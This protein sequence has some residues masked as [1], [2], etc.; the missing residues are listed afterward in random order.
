ME[1]IVFETD[2]PSAM[3]IMWPAFQRVTITTPF[4]ALSLSVEE[5]LKALKRAKVEPHKSG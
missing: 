2:R 4:R 3:I 1:K 5:C